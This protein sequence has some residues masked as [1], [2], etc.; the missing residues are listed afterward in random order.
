MSKLPAHLFVADNGDL[1]DTR[2]PNWAA[3]PLR[4][5]YRGASSEVRNLAAVKAQLRAGEHTGL[6]GYPLFFWAADGE[7]LSFDAVRDNFREVASAMMQ[8]HNPR[9]GWRVVGVEIN[10]EDANLVCSHTGKPI[11]SAYGPEED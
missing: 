11:Q 5:A 10:Y 3:S 1:F 9:D 2:L 4:R 7:A 8:D 6:G